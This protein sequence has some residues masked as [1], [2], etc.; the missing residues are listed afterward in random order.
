MQQPQTTPPR[1]EMINITKTWVDT[2]IARSQ[3]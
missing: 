3:P 2:F 1:V